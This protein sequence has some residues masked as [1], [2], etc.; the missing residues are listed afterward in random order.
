MAVRDAPHGSSQR[1]DAD[2]PERGFNAERFVQR[3]LG[4]ADHQKRNVLLIGPYRRRRGMKDDDLL[5]TSCLD[6]SHT[7]LEFSDVRVTDRAIDEA[8]EL[9]VEQALWVGKADGFSRYRFHF[10][11]RQRVSRLECHRSWLLCVCTTRYK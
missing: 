9:E 6:L 3:L 8:P 11:D 1:L 10:R 4:I 2:E 7:F 5:D